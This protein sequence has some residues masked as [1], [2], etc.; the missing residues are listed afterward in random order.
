[1]RFFFM[2]RPLISNNQ[3]VK[4][5]SKRHSNKDCDRNQTVQAVNHLASDQLPDMFLVN[6]FPLLI[7]H[8]L[9][10]MLSHPLLPLS[11]FQIP[12]TFWLS[13]LSVSGASY[14]GVLQDSGW[15]APLNALLLQYFSSKH[16]SFLPDPC[17]YVL[18]CLAG[19]G[20]VAPV[21]SGVHTG[22]I[23]FI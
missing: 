12:L 23:F 13:L 1:M 4:E 20:H 5:H 18:A 16:L 7:G 14:P 3:P 21:W 2:I 8:Q 11:S 19:S 17:Y 10:F 22:A 9:S 15:S 6:C